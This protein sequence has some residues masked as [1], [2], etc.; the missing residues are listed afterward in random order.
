[1]SNALGH[2]EAG[3]KMLNGSGLATMR[4]EDERVEAALGPEVVQHGH[5]G[6]HVVHVVGVRGVLLVGPLVGRGDVPVKQR[7]FGLALV[8]HGVEPDHVPSKKPQQLKNTRS[9]DQSQL[10]AAWDTFQVHKKLLEFFFKNI[11]FRRAGRSVNKQP[12][13]SCLFVGIRVK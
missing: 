2:H 10:A 3:H 9:R 6:E 5:V 13:V 12:M 7:V 1:M 8:V 11:F 4:P